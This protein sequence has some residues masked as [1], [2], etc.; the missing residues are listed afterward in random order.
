MIPPGSTI[1]ILGGGQL[2]RM[3]GQAARSLGYGYIVYEPQPNCP[4]SHVA[5]Q[6]ISAPYD[7]QAALER[8]AKISDVIT[9]EFEN[10][11]SE[12]TRQ[13]SA[14][15]LLHPRPEIL[16]IC[17]NREREKTFLRDNGFPCAPFRILDTLEDLQTAL[18]EIGAP[19]VLKT[20]AFGYDGKG[21][22]KIDNQNLDTEELW[23]RFGQQRAVLEG[24]MDFRMEISVMVAANAQG[25][26]L[27]H[28]VA[29]NIH[30]N[31]I[32]DYSIVPARISA[33]LQREAEE[34]AKDIARKLGLVGL[35]GVELFVM[36]DGSLAVNELAPRPHNSAHYSLD[37]CAT[38]Q[39]EQ[40]VRAVCDLP[41]GSTALHSPITMVNI[42][43]DAWQDD[44]QPNFAA[45]MRDPAVKLHLYGKKDP[46][47]GRK[48]GH[49]T[50][51]APTAEESY[52]GAQNLKQLL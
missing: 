5:D 46:R 45:L 39:F 36:T 37:A 44:R 14:T 28:P 52:Q 51:F 31:H 38:S 22:I 1:G 4:A 2:G 33:E 12:A 13:L 11:P 21:Q 23:Q 25:E 42:L 3:T 40:F 6:Q 26:M 34:L 32:L 48:M 16:H 35:L 9:Y 27:T 7:D 50:V 20:A 17:Q 24:W 43:G 18:A 41:L 10:V 30:T 19:S 47:P 15:S 8:F 29:E 49:F